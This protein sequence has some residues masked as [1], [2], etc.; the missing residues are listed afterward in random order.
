MVTATGRLS[1]TNPN[2]QN[3]PIRTEEGRIFR[4]IFI[5][6]E[7]RKLIDAD[8]S[9]IEL[10][11]LADISKDQTMI[12]SFENNEDIHTTTASKVFNLK[13]EEVTPD[14]RSD[15]KAVNF[16]MVYG[17]SAFGLSQ[18]LK[19]T[20]ALAQEYIDNYFHRFAGVAKYMDDIVDVAKEQG[21]VDTMFGRRRYLPELESKNW[22]VRNFGERI[23]LNMPIQGTAAD[24]IKLAMIEI[25]RELKRRNLKSKLILQIHDEL[26]ID[27]FDDEIDEV[28]NIV[29]SKMEEVVNLS[30]PLIADIGVGDSWYDA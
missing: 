21:Y 25:Y 27:T 19:I 29:K 14:I 8:Y 6:S 17:I 3:I 20:R 18:D 28:K 22:N 16:G 9:Q 10:R 12:E 15:A 5:A 23:A 24:I 30:V 1:S 26:I 13:P 7:N 2:L 11:L 4:K